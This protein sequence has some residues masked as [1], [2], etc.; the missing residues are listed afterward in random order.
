[1]LVAVRKS[2][3][4][5]TKYYL[6]HDYLRTLWAQACGSRQL[7]QVSVQAVKAGDW[8][9]VAEVTKYCVKPFDYAADVESGLA[10][11]EA[12]GYTLK[13][14]RFLQK[15]GVLQKYYKEAAAA[16]PDVLDV[17]GEESME[18]MFDFALIWDGEKY[19][20]EGG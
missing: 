8:Q 5:D 11:V 7:F 3:F 6:K 17:S 18:Q 13:G 9:G 4:N 2:Y 20:V 10:I 15:Y 16:V 19:V 12:L 14:R 1:M